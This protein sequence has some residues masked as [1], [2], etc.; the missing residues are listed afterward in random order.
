MIYGTRAPQVFRADTPKRLG[1]N[2]SQVKKMVE[3]MAQ[4]IEKLEQQVTQLLTD[5]QQLLEKV[6]RTS[7]NSSSPPSS[8]PPGFGKEL[9]K[10]KSNKKRGGQPGHEGK[11]RDLYPIEKCNPHSALQNVIY[12]ASTNL[13][14]NR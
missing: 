8:D 14:K 4:G 3:S 12:S 9:H 7:K 11:S 5:Q 13:T 2:S 6:K 10:N 1:E